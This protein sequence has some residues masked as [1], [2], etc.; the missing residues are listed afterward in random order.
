MYRAVDSN[1]QTLD[2]MFSAKRDKKAAKRFFIKVLKA[3]HNKQ[4]RVINADQNPACPPAIEELK[5]S[6]LLSNE[7]ELSE[8]E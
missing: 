4:P 5:E 2:F 3:K 6:G 1:G 8:A 7:C